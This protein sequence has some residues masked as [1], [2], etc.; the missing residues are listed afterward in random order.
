MAI[1]RLCSARADG[2]RRAGRVALSPGR[3]RRAAASPYGAALRWALASR[4]L[5]RR[6]Q[7][8]G[9]SP[10]R[11]GHAR[12]GAFLQLGA[13]AG[14]PCV[15]ADPV[16][17][18]SWLCARCRRRPIAACSSPLLLRQPEGAPSTSALKSAG[19]RRSARRSRGRP[20]RA[21]GEPGRRGYAE[22]LSASPSP[23]N[24]NLVWHPAEQDW[25]LSLPGALR[26][27]RRTDRS[28]LP[29][30]SSERLRAGWLA[31]ALRQKQDTETETLDYCFPCDA[32]AR[33][34]GRPSPPLLVQGSS[35]RKR[36]ACRILKLAVSPQGSVRRRCPHGCSR[37]SRP[38]RSV[39]APA[40]RTCRAFG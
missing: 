1:P 35:E 11:R 16:V 6:R 38:P 17:G 30:T 3:A 13:G 23:L 29:W 40:R 25:P 31:I 33:C 24:R 12:A 34:A 9:T 10:S 37:R 20:R 21:T 39:P 22:R 19:R 14:L 7:A 36:R 32:A 18:P 4:A 28:L 15:P 26:S 5:R 2:A 8:P 27:Q